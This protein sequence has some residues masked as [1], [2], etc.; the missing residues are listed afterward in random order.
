MLYGKLMKLSFPLVKGAVVLDI[1]VG[2]GDADII[3][4]GLA[5]YW[6]VFSV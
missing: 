3:K 6:D 1:P 2:F 4:I 5:R